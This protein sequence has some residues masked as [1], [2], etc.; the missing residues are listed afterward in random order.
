MDIWI[1][2]FFNLDETAVT[3]SIDDALVGLYAILAIVATVVWR[4]EL[5]ASRR[6]QVF[7]VVAFAVIL[8]MV[9]LDIL[10]NRESTL[11]AVFESNTASSLHTALSTA[12]DSAKIFAEA[13]IALGLLAAFRHA[14]RP[15]S[16]SAAVEPGFA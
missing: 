12:E 4:R 2:S 7:F 16:Q 6:T 13:L 15:G 10:T 1:H 11:D 3:D 9:A 14:R 5:L 8:V